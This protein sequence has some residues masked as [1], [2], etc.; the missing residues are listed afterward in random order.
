MRIRVEHEGLLQFAR[1]VPMGKERMSMELIKH[2]CHGDNPRVVTRPV[3]RARISIP[4]TLT[5]CTEYVY[6]ELDNA[7]A[8]TGCC[9]T[10]PDPVISQAGF[11]T[12]LLCVPTLCQLS[13]S[14]YPAVAIAQ[15]H[16]QHEL[17]RITWYRLGGGT[18]GFTH[19][20]KYHVN[21]LHA[22]ITFRQR[23]QDV[24]S[25]ERGSC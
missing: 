22:Q 25:C 23:C 24:S 20:H 9:S 7:C 16:R 4:C 2:R 10:S 17:D 11:T 14:P 13:T 3:S 12:A 6:I 5:V 1:P 18:L 19:K 8:T 15:G 21:T